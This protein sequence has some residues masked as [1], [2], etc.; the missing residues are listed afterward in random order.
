MRKPSHSK[1]I[2]TLIV[3]VLARYKYNPFPPFQPPPKTKTRTSFSYAVMSQLLVYHILMYNIWR[4]E[5]VSPKVCKIHQR[6]D[7]VVYTI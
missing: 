5:N 2:L 1:K 3:Q 4:Q 6:K 7:A